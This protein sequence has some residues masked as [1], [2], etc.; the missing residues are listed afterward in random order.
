MARGLD[1]ALSHGGAMTHC[2][3]NNE[4]LAQVGFV[5]MC[6]DMRRRL[7]PL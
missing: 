4:P 5:G 6:R 3:A 7:V 2:V 1:L